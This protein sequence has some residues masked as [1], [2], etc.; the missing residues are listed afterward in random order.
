MLLLILDIYHF[1]AVPALPDVATA[2]GFVEVDAIDRERF[3]AVGAFLRLGLS[4]HLQLLFKLL[5]ISINLFAFAI[6][7]YSQRRCWV[8]IAN[9]IIAVSFVDCSD[10]VIKYY[11]VISIE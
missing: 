2:V 1:F 11:A 9:N 8:I 7:E 3:V 6:Y 10:L 5:T 4:F